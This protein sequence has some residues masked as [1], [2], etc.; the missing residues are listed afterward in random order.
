[1][2]GCVSEPASRDSR[3]NRAQ[4]RRIASL[5]V[6]LLER[7]PAVEVGL[8]RKVDDGHAATAQLP[9]DL[10]AVE[11]ARVFRLRRFVSHKESDTREARPDTGNSPAALVALR[12]QGLLQPR[13]G[14][15]A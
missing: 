11:D 7:D 15:A 5:R 14:A 1:M 8:A 4:Q 10:I 9:A 2:F 3:R 12:L 13:S 6:Q